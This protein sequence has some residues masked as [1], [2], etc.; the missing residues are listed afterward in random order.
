M[1][2]PYGWVGGGGGGAAASSYSGQAQGGDR[3]VG[4]GGAG[5]TGG[6]RAGPGVRNTGGGAGGGWVVLGLTP[7]GAAGGSGLV[8]V[9]YSTAAATG[10]T[11]TGG[12]KVVV[13]GVGAYEDLPADG[14]TY[15]VL[16]TVGSATFS[17]A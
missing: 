10:M 6:N 14:N 11:V 1:G 13:P 3:G 16:T 12:D 15:H 8:I 17:I 5:S 9:A 2:L 7:I 4:G